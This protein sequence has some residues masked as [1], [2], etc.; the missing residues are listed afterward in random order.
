[1]LIKVLID[2]IFLLFISLSLANEEA[3]SSPLPMTISIAERSNGT[4]EISGK[5]SFKSLEKQRINCA[6][7]DSYRGSSHSTVVGKQLEAIFESSQY[8]P[9]KRGD[10]TINN[11]PIEEK[12]LFTITPSQDL[13][14]KYFATVK[15]SDVLILHHATPIMSTHCS[16][17]SNPEHH[18]FEYDVRIKY[19]DQWNPINPSPIKASSFSF[20]LYKNMKKRSLRI[21]GTNIFLLSKSSQLELIPTIKSTFS[22]HIKLYGPFPQKK[23]Y[24]VETNSPQSPISSGI[25]SINR[26]RQNLFD[27]IQ[28]KL[29]NWNHWIIIALLSYQW[30]IEKLVNWRVEDQWLLIGLID[31]SICEALRSLSLRNSLFNNYEKGTSLINMNYSYVQDLNAAILRK[32]HP[33]LRLTDDLNISLKFNKNRKLA[34]IRQVMALR[35][36]RSIMGDKNFRYMIRRF[37]QSANLEIKDPRGFLNLLAETHSPVPSDI[38]VQTVSSFRKWWTSFEWPDYE[39]KR[40]SKTKTSSGAWLTEV[41]G[42]SHNGFKDTV[43]IKVP[44]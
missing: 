35:Q 2:L 9:P 13:S 25:I 16:N 18:S 5:I 8:S 26:P 22:S 4:F 28:N 34:Y 1:M 36:A 10:L 14:W 15:D 42:I 31:F 44:Q 24:I 38:R 12:Q 6:Y 11:N 40:V 41:Q 32:R 21:H 27:S 23:L 17:L 20:G 29:L 33:Y 19:P 7:F 39:L 37:T 3:S 30:H 43:E